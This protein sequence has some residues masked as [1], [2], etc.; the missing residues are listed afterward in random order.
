MKARREVRGVR[1]RLERGMAVRNWAPTQVILAGERVLEPKP[2][3][4]VEEELQKG[5]YD[6]QKKKETY[7]VG[8][9]PKYDFVE[10]TCVCVDS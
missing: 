7:W 5:S 10:L 9:S 3:E 4:K 1:E 2:R 6:D 8:F